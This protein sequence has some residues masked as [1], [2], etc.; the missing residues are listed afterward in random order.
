[1]GGT[2]VKP[3][4]FHDALKQNVTDGWD[5]MVAYAQIPL[6]RSLSKAWDR[7][8]EFTKLTY[9]FQVIYDTVVID[10]NFVVDLGAPSLQFDTTSDM[11][12]AIL[13]MMING[14]VTTDTTISGVKTPGTPKAIPKDVYQLQVT[15]PI[16]GITGNQVWDHDHAI[17][18]EGKGDDQPCHLIFHFRNDR[19]TWD[20]LGHCS[21]VLNDDTFDKQM[22][23]SL[24]S[25]KDHFKSKDNTHWIDYKRGTLSQVLYDVVPGRIS[26]GFI[27]TTGKDGTQNPRFNTKSK[28]TIAPIINDYEASIVI[29]HDL[30]VDYV[31]DQMKTTFKGQKI[32]IAKESTLTG[33]KL[34]MTMDDTASWILNFD[35]TLDLFDN[36]NFETKFTWTWAPELDIE[37]YEVEDS[38]GINT[39]QWGVVKTTS[40]LSTASFGASF[41]S[42]WQIMLTKIWY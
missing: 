28:K 11:A 20:I 35:L 17:K 10:Q 1:M 3:E 9:S 23:Q 24:N 36:S 15:V 38:Q 4:E 40:E 16:V 22:Q 8:A 7:K 2:I 37:W 21:S 13:T 34:S 18:F 32:T 30:F 31:C 5:M 33:A 42:I 12:I 19:S 26:S 25:F 41:T 6:N 27:T 29:H 39:H 14:T